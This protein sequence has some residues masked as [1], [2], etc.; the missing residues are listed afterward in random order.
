ML[1]W[2]GQVGDVTNNKKNPINLLHHLEYTRTEQP[3]TRAHRFIAKGRV[4]INIYID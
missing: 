4:S 3:H 2:D 1:V